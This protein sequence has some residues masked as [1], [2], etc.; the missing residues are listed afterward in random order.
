MFMRSSAS[1][2]EVGHMEQVD[3]RQGRLPHKEVAAICLHTWGCAVQPGK[4]EEVGQSWHW[5]V[6]PMIG[7]IELGWFVHLRTE[8]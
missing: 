4:R 6:I 5:A 1:R 7:N 8:A 2:T 3:P